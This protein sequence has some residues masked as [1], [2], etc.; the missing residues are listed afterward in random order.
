MCDAVFVSLV[1]FKNS[2]HILSNAAY[3]LHS[4]SVKTYNSLNLVFENTENFIVVKCSKCRQM[5]QRKQILLHNDITLCM[6]VYVQ[7]ILQYEK[8][9]CDFR[10]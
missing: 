9:F 4:I 3:N 7:K 10:S 1:V 8:A 2:R 6:M 5:L